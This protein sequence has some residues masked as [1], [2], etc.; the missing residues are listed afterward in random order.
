MIRKLKSFQYQIML[1]DNLC[2]ICLGGPLDTRAISLIH[3]LKKEL[4]NYEKRSFVLCFRGVT[5]FGQGIYRDIVQLQSY[6]RN[7]L[8]GELLICDLSIEWGPRMVDQGIFRQNEVV[9]SIRMAIQ[10]MGK[11]RKSFKPAVA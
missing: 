6:I 5:K 7:D 2:I 1:R 11:R 3:E 8:S 9:H 4:I 10:E